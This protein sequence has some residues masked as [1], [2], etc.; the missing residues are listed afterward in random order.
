M[1]KRITVFWEIKFNPIYEKL[2]EFVGD[3]RFY[4]VLR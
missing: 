3:M 1:E 4:R 2:A